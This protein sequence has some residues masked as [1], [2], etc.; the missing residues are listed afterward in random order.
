MRFNPKDMKLHYGD[1]TDSTCL[2]KIINEVK[3]TEIYNLG[4]Q[5]HVKMVTLEDDDRSANN[6]TSYLSLL[7][8][9]VIFSFLNLR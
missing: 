7:S 8:R 6:D 1:L 3:P 2:V 5:S 9:K 4:A